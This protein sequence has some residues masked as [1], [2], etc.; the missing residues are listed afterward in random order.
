MTLLEARESELI[1]SRDRIEAKFQAQEQ[2]LESVYT[3]EFTVH[4][5]NEECTFLLK[6][7]SNAK[8]SLLVKAIHNGASRRVEW[9]GLPR[10]LV[11]YMS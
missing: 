6:H 5:T 2:A 10:D 4:P 8:K 3:R 11:K 7:I 1:E 9:T